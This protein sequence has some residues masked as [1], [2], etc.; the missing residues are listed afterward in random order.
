MKKRPTSICWAGLPG[1]AGKTSSQSP[2]PLPCAGAMALRSAR[3]AW[4]R[5][6][7]EYFFSSFQALNGVQAQEDE[8]QPDRSAFALPEADGAVA[9]ARGA[10]LRSWVE[11]KFL[12]GQWPAVDVATLCWHLSQCGL[13]GFAVR[14]LALVS[15]YGATAFALPSQL[16]LNHYGQ[17]A[18]DMAANPEVCS[19]STTAPTK[20][21][22]CCF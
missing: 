22:P 6:P 10:A 1:K 12:L 21:P 2:W 9:A 16:G 18:Q 17:L 7:E 19:F 4:Q 3:Q 20:A 14:S 8:R 13:Q 15:L 5:R 11:R